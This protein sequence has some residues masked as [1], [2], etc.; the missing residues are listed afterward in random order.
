MAGDG[1]FNTFARMLMALIR[2]ENNAKLL[3]DAYLTHEFYLCQ[4]SLLPSDIAPNYAIVVARKDDRPTENMQIE[5][6]HP[7]SGPRTVQNVKTLYSAPLS[8]AG[9]VEIA[10]FYVSTIEDQLNAMV[11]KL[12]LLNH[13]KEAGIELLSNPV[14][15]TAQVFKVLV[16]PEND[17][18]AHARLFGANLD[19][20]REQHRNMLADLFEDEDDTDD[21]D[22]YER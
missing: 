9:L 6:D 4:V 19:N 5:F 3:N 11:N 16:A 1:K 14:K 21:D 13:L 18:E 8:A 12:L 17:V 7:G 22:L 2:L 15:P 20:Q 10:D